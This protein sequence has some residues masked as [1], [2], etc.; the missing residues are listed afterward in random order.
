MHFLGFKPYLLALNIYLHPHN[1]QKHMFLVFYTLYSSIIYVFIWKNRKKIKLGRAG[2]SPSCHAFGPG[3]APWPCR[4][5]TGPVHYVPC[6]V[7]GRPAS[8]VR[9]DIYSK[10]EYNKL[11]GLKSAKKIWNMHKT[12]HGGD[13]SHQNHQERYERGRARKIKS[14]RQHNKPL[15]YVVIMNS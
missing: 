1:Q 7:S 6:R 11:Q 8:P 3:T 15:N 9:L 14:G 5:G 12:S 2:P 13:K 4:V 10:E